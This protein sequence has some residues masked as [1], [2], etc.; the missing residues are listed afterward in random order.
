LHTLRS[1]YCTHKL[2]KRSSG[3][4]TQLSS[5]AA[6]DDKTSD[7]PY[8]PRNVCYDRACTLLPPF[9]PPFMAAATSFL[10]PQIL[11]A[12]PIHWPPLSQW[13]LW[14]RSGL[15][16]LESLPH[17][18]A[19]GLL[20]AKGPSEGIRLLPLLLLRLLLR[21]RCLYRLLQSPLVHVRHSDRRLS[22]A[23]PR[24]QAA[25]L[26]RA[27][28]PPRRGAAGQSTVPSAAAAAAAGAPCWGAPSAPRQSAGTRAACLPAC[29]SCAGT[30]R[31]WRPWQPPA[32]P[33]LQPPPARLAGRPPG[34]G[35]PGPVGA[36][37]SRCC[38]AASRA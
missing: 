11:D 10:L 14:D 13:R 5:P 4:L 37:C 29:A 33:T 2:Y 38:A 6:L 23:L 24:R 7:H 9:D 22:L 35:P 36:G 28:L 34:R 31:G 26:R 18:P 19:T 15:F 8:A 12:N 20:L 17:R 27:L 30:L 3:S 25:H 16:P 1:I 32:G 21:Q